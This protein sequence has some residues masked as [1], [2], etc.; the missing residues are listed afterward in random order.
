MLSSRNGKAIY[1]VLA[2]KIIDGILS[3]RLKADDRLL[4]IRDYAAEVQVNQNTVKRT[5]D[6]LSDQGLIYNRRGV[7]FY[8]AA[9]AR[10]IGESLRSR[11]LLGSELDKLFRQLNLLGITV[12]ELA[13]KYRNFIDSQKD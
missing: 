10:K 9:D 4:S 2:D 1:L 5:Y 13:E 12:D 6:Y 11:Q 8:V 3:D 7:G